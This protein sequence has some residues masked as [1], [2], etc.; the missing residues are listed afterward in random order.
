MRNVVASVQLAQEKELTTG[1]RYAAAKQGA[2]SGVSEIRRKHLH[3]IRFRRTHNR[4]MAKTPDLHVMRPSLIDESHTFE[5][6]TLPVGRDPKTSAD[7][8]GVN[9]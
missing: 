3:D 7:R 5:K 1:S 4:K 9:I 6:D 8:V 2:A